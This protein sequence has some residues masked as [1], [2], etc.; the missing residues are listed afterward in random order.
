MLFGLDNNVV[1]ALGAAGFVYMY[2]GGGQTA[3]PLARALGGSGIAAAAVGGAV[4]YFE[5][6]DKL[7]SMLGM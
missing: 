5:L 3:A 2:S 6:G 7:F 1:A 4:Y